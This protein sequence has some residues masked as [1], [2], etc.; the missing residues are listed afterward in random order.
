MPILCR[1]HYTELNCGGPITEPASLAAWLVVPGKIVPA[2]TPVA[3]LALPTGTTELHVR[4][5]CF[6]EALLL[7][8]GQGV[9]SGDPILHVLA[10]GDAIPEG[11]RYCYLDPATS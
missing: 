5:R 4:F 8:Q 1:I 3:R 11:F 6:I 2:D 10:D 9:K 7:K